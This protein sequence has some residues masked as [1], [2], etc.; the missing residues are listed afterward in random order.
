MPGR[1]GEAAR[2]GKLWTR[3]SFAWPA[4]PLTL[5][6]RARKEWE[7]EKGSEE[8]GEGED[9]KNDHVGKCET[10][11]G[12][13]EE[14]KG[15]D[16]KE[17]RQVTSASVRGDIPTLEIRGDSLT[18]VNWERGTSKNGPRMAVVEKGW[19]HPVD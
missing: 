18:I 6:G 1:F 4:L 17:P 13:P 15:G 2:A 9:F 16:G 19:T 14:A 3:E 8:Q 12:A 11:G 10:L 7:E 5:V